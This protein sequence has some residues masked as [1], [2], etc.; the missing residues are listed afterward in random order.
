MSWARR[1]IAHG[2]LAGG[3]S[4]YDG[5]WES[6]KPPGLSRGGEDIA[7]EFSLDGHATLLADGH[8]NGDVDELAI[9]MAD[10]HAGLAGHGGVGGAAA[11]LIAEDGVVAIRGDAADDVAGIDVLQVNGGTGWAK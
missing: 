1:R 5:Q 10:Q 11:E 7:P 4:C 6:L 2:H 9:D 3:A 8:G